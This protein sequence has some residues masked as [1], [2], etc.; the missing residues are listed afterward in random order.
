[1]LTS[2]ICRIYRHVCMHIWED[3]HKHVHTQK[4]KNV[5]NEWLNTCCDGLRGKTLIMELE[6]E[7][8]SVFTI[9]ETYSLQGGSVGGNM[10]QFMM[11][12]IVNYMQSQLPSQT[13]VSTVLLLQDERRKLAGQPPWSTVCNG[14]NQKDHFYTR[15]KVRPSFWNLSSHL[16][17]RAMAFICMSYKHIRTNYTHVYLHHIDNTHLYAYYTPTHEH[18]S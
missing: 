7:V 18:I 9:K 10:G 4:P 15:W 6:T 5:L 2:C 1:M 11:V 3:M 13:S 8:D 16:H 17:T 12:Q 14:R